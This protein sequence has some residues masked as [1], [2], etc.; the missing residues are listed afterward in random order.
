MHNKDLY[1][2]YNIDL[3]RRNIVRVNLKVVKS[4]TNSFF[5][6]SLVQTKKTLYESI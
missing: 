6:G 3:K 5:K 1:I 2:G 4:G